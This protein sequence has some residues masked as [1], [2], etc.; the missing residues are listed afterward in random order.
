MPQL[1]ALGVAIADL[2]DRA[3][4]ESD[5]VEL[6]VR[7]ITLEVAVQGAVAQRLHQ[8]VLRQRE[9]VHTDV[10]V[11][12][13]GKELDRARQQR[14][15]LGGRGHVLVADQ[16]LRAEHLRQ[17]RIAVGRNAIRLGLHDGFQRV[18]EARRGL[19]GQPVDQVDR[20]RAEAVLTRLADQEQ[21]PLLVLQAVH[22]LLHLGIEI[23]DT[24]RQ[25]VE[26]H[27]RQPR[28][29]VLVDAAGI[30][31][32]GVLALLAMV[33]AEVTEQPVHHLAEL[34]LVQEGRRAAA[35][36]QLV[37][38]PA[39]IEQLSLQ[40]HLLDQVLHV[41][42]SAVLVPGDDLVAAAVITERMAERHM[43]V[44]R[45]RVSLGIVAVA[46]QRQALVIL[47][48]ETVVKLHGGRVRG[49]ARPA[50]VVALDQV[51][52]EFC[53]LGSHESPHRRWA[54]R[55]NPRIPTGPGIP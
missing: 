11:A 53:R 44:N 13:A 38:P 3:H 52:V 37:D 29:R 26:A 47:L 51:E 40:A 5:Q 2:A 22:R 1:D 19:L 42:I 48:A 41:G 32:Y 24:Q 21:R 12:A 16:P 50:A 54:G 31:L 14:E 46:R 28:N 43:H 39:G 8:V 20:D 55:R 6:C 27:L 25:P 9:V 7:G 10:L 36:M 45:Q 4:A 49:V 15:L 17:V 35:E 34:P 23:L 30:D 33:Q 18:S